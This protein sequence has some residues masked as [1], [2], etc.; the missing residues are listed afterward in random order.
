MKLIAKE[1]LS[2][3]SKTIP[4]IL[5][6][7]IIQFSI[8]KHRNKTGIL[9]LYFHTIL[10]FI[11]YPIGFKIVNMIC[12]ILLFPLSFQDCF[13]SEQNTRKRLVQ[14]PHVQP[15]RQHFRF[16]VR[17]KAEKGWQ[18]HDIYDDQW[19]RIFYGEVTD[20]RCM[21]ASFVWLQIR[22]YS[23]YHSS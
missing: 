19:R 16:P 7:F 4:T 1:L 2:S 14:L 20:G 22:L 11:L 6:V 17:S 8:C 9:S 3:V 10:L 15:F 12:L 18:F 23:T 13:K 5:S 21:H